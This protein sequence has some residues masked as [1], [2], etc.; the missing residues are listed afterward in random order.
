MDSPPIV[1]QKFFKHM[2]S[3]TGEQPLPPVAPFRQ[4]RHFLAS[5][6]KDF[7]GVLCGA[8]YIRVGEMPHEAPSVKNLGAHNKQS[9][10]RMLTKK[11]KKNRRSVIR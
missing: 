3:I 1:A 5:S 10:G 9:L 11:K 2:K 4:T 8:Y 6:L 7:L